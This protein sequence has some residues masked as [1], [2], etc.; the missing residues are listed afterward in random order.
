M[1]NHTYT[2]HAKG[3]KDYYECKECPEKFL[4][5]KKL[6]YHKLKHL[7]KKAYPCDKCL[8]SYEKKEALKQHVLR[9]LDPNFGK[10]IV[11]K[12]LLCTELHRNAQCEKVFETQEELEEHVKW[13]H[14]KVQP[15]QCSICEKKFRVKADMT[16]HVGLVHEGKKRKTCTECGKLIFESDLEQHLLNVHGTR[17]VVDWPNAEN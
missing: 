13:V 4:T 3:L 2:S 12:Q 6:N 15:F 1:R 17:K 8:R 5:L 7:P 16:L 10:E 9:H 14:V 11:K